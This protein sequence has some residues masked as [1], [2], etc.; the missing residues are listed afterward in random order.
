MYSILVRFLQRKSV[1]CRPSTVSCLA[2]RLAHFGT[3]IAWIDP[4]GTPAT[5]QRCQHIEPWMVALTHAENTMS[6]GVISVAEQA[7]RILAAANFLSEI[8]EWDWPEAFT[9]RLFYSAD[10]P[11][12]PQLLP[13]F[14][15]PDADRRLTQELTASKY[16]LAADALC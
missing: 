12:L 16:R 2:T 3:F 9:R 5:L 7:R 8:N 10:N 11:R 13:R 1:T 4:D 6:G 14:L 15:P